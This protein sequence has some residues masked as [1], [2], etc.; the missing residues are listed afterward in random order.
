MKQIP[1]KFVGLIILMVIC[2]KTSYSQEWLIAKIFETGSLER[3]LPF[4]NDYFYD[5]ITY[6]KTIRNTAY[7]G[8]KGPVKSVKHIS[9]YIN[10]DTIS[11]IENKTILNFN[12]SKL[13]TLFIQGDTGTISRW[14]TEHYFYNKKQLSKRVNKRAD[15]GDTEQTK[16]IY[17][18][19]GYLIQKTDSFRGKFSSENEIYQ[20]HT[21]YNYTDSFK[22]VKFKYVP[23]T[24][25]FR[26]IKGG[27][28]E[29]QFDE[30]GN[31]KN[32]SVSSI[33]YDSLGRPTF[34]FINN[35][36]GVNS[37]LCIEVTVKYDSAGNVIEQ[38]IND[39]TTRNAL[40]SFSSHFKAKYNEHNL[41]AEK[42]Y[43]AMDKLHGFFANVNGETNS[44]KETYN[45]TYD[46]YRN[47]TKVQV[48][49]NNVLIK[50]IERQI[51]YY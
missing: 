27:Q 25:V 31:Y 14:V 28:I 45:Y 6:A 41:I 7:F 43:L 36:C 24:K 5:E 38:T 44:T 15:Y 33:K 16:Y 3:P 1:V 11:G 18:N 23:V 40:W 29:F 21:K 49:R 2:T 51:E 50:I 47:W 20:Y 30:Y 13:L 8:L 17:N 26:D 10:N 9:Y 32:P 46:D 48:F 42:E 12:Q 37:A 35:G 34:Y 4:L 22:S 39:M 19:L